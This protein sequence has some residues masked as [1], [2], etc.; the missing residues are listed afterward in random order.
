MI[1]E[2]AG[3]NLYFQTISRVGETIDSGTA[4]RQAP[5]PTQSSR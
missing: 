3:D 4:G 2:I 5:P 1:V